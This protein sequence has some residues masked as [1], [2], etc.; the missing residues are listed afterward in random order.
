MMNEIKI[1]SLL[2]SHL[3]HLSDKLSRRM[4]DDAMMYD[5][6]AISNETTL[7]YFLEPNE[8]SGGVGLFTEENLPDGVFSSGTL[9]ATAQIAHHNHTAIYPR[10]F[11]TLPFAEKEVRSTF[12]EPPRKTKYPA[13][14]KAVLK[15]SIYDLNKI[16]VGKIV[17]VDKI[18]H[19][20]FNRYNNVSIL[21][22][23]LTVDKKRQQQIDINIENRSQNHQHSQL[24]YNNVKIAPIQQES[25]K[26]KSA[27]FALHWFDHGGAEKF[28]IT[29]MKKARSMGFHVYCI[30]DKRGNKYYEDK[31]RDICENI[32]NIA[33]SLPKEYW[34]RFYINANNR[35]NVGVF[36]IHHAISA[37]QALPKIR[38]LT[39]TQ[40]ILDTTHIVE[41]TDGGYVRVSGVFSQYLDYHHTISQESSEYLANELLV[42]YDKI[43]LGYLF[44]QESK[45]E[46][47]FDKVYSLNKECHISFVGRFVN[48]KRPYLFIELISKI[49]NHPRLKSRNIVF[50][51]VGD[52]PLADICD[53]LIE[54]KGLGAVIN[55]LPADYDVDQLLKESHFL[56]IPS[57]NEG[58]TLVAY[59]AILNNCI[60]V[61]T[62]VGSQKEIVAPDSL[63]SRHPDLFIESCLSLLD[64]AFDETKYAEQLL[65]Q[66]FDAINTIASKLNWENVLDEIYGSVKDV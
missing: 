48:Q 37:Y 20:L 4:K 32:F 24:Y 1:N 66:Q 31:A 35:L 62:D 34:H 14:S 50:N 47:S 64:K 36:H 49:K 9:V 42:P 51:M 43:K 63:L 54:K 11:V 22:D 6:L 12:Q 7:L 13:I 23:V 8:T 38:A 21:D 44:N 41:H 26:H 19:D 53:Q 29:S 39:N 33:D 60:V 18:G 3:T 55:R 40:K 15:K 25:N 45:L 27:L 56:I 61:S 58:L 10:I 65:K 59:E 57:E 52:G 30:V 16:G 46:L 17:N 28:A 5:I 2:P